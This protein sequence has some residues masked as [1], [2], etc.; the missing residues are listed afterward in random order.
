MSSISG[1]AER[2][3]AAVGNG[4]AV[5]PTRFQSI[6]V[7]WLMFSDYGPVAQRH[8]AIAWSCVFGCALADAVWLPNSRLSMA[9][10]NW[11]SLL[12][13]IVCCALAAAFIAAATRRL[14]SDESRPAIVLRSALGLTELLYRASLPI[15]ALFTAGGALSYLITSADL[16]LRDDLLAY[17]DRVLGF[18]W[19]GFLNATNSSPFLAKMLTWVYQ[20]TGPVTLLVTVWLPLH[21]R[22]ERLAEFI[23]ILSLSAVALC[24]TMWLVPAA[25][26]FAF[27]EPAPE[28][29]GNYSAQGE[30]WFFARAFTM[31]R[32][33]ALSVIDLSA[34]QGVVSFPS[35]H[36]MLGLMTIYAIRDTRWLMIP[37][38]LLN[39]TMIVST[40]PVGGHHLADVLAGAG[41]TFAAIILVRRSTGSTRAPKTWRQLKLSARKSGQAPLG[42]GPGPSI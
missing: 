34:L 16:P 36:T 30:M 41:L 4:V 28:L 13:G 25:G 33:G 27:Y 29:F 11:V 1:I 18:D 9:S 6:V 7:R 5:D 21:R 31:L 19:L 23:A 24:A 42:D 22:G 3:T 26:A 35:F 39:G 32:N 20:T 17:V 38:L 40:L 15:V 12:Q 14:R 8:M 10:S 37:V 2:T